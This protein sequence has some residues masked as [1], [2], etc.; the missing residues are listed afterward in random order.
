MFTASQLAPPTVC[1]KSLVEQRLCF[2][3][4]SC[5]NHTGPPRRGPVLPNIHLQLVA[6]VKYDFS[7][8]ISGKADG[9][10]VFGGG[11]SDSNWIAG[12]D[13]RP[14]PAISPQNARALTLNGP[15]GDGAFIVFHVHKNLA[16]G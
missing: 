11:K 13:G 6:I 16:M 15:I 9:R 5:K 7:H 2:P 3:P 4:I 1:A 10:S 14:R 8:F 12:L